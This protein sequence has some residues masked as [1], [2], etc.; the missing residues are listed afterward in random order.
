M[1]WR[2]SGSSFVDKEYSLE[3]RGQTKGDD[4]NLLEAW[5]SG[6]EILWRAENS[7][8]RESVQNMARTRKWGGWDEK[9]RWL[10]R[11]NEV[12]GARK[13]GGWDEKMRWLGWENEVS[14]CLKWQ[15]FPSFDRN[16]SRELLKC[17]KVNNKRT[18]FIS[19]TNWVENQNSIFKKV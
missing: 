5:N 11:E 2:R 14:E 1:T 12:A 6:W 13:W 17:Y 19:H 4:I 15:E 10:G 9:M 18:N 16:S 7:F 3:T 8:F